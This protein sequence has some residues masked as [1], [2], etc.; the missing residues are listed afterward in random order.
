MTRFTL[1]VY[2]FT[3]LHYI[4]KPAIRQEPKNGLPGRLIL[5]K[6]RL[7]L[8]FDTHS[9]LITEQRIATIGVL[10][11]LHALICTGQKKEQHRQHRKN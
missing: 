8:S 11:T 7:K 5:I 4:H 3:G 1:P 10:R 6:E 9:G 2:R